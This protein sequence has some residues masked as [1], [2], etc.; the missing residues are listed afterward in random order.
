MKT[1]VSLP[2]KLFHKAD[3]LAKQLGVSR[4]ELYKI[5]LEHLL[6]KHESRQDI[7][8][9]I[10]EV[11]AATSTTLDENLRDYTLQTLRSNEWT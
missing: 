7:I 10:N 1:A 5:A 2:D 4:S 9:S 6:D 3:A 11:C 8:D